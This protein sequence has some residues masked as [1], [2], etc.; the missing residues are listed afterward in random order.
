MKV[1][2]KSFYARDPAIVAKEL[3]GKILVRNL[4]GKILSG[5]IVETEAY[6]GE[7]DPASRARRGK[8]PHC[9]LMWEEPGTVFIYM[10]HNNW[11]FNI[12]TM[13]KGIASAV[14]IRALQPLKG[15]EVMKENRNVSDIKNLTSGP[16]KLTKALAIT[17]ELNGA[18]VTNSKSE[19]YITEGDNEKFETG[20]SNRIGVSKDLKKPLRFFIK[21]NPFVSR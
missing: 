10:V 16:G 19:V 21:N 14:L 5:K 8:L 6:Y 2:P 13:P 18:S 12:V 17:K 20:K 3:L 4:N 11:L 7:K 9:E 1:L 15:I